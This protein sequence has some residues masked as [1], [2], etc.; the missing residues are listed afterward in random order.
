MH[1]IAIGL[2]F[3]MAATAHASTIAKVHACTTAIVHA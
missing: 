2:A 1:T 3:T